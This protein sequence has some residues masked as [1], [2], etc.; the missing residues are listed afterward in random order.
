[1]DMKIKHISWFN[2][3]ALSIF[4]LWIGVSTVQAQSKK[5][6]PQLG[7]SP[8]AE[9][10]KAMTLEEKLQTVVGTFRAPK[11]PPGPPPGIPVRPPLPTGFDFD[12]LFAKGRIQGTAGE[13]FAIPR[14]GIP[15][16]V[17]ADGPAGLRIFPFRNK[18]SSHGYYAT[19]FPIATLMAST[20][21]TALVKRVGQAI[22]EELN[23]YGVDVLLSPGIN[24][25][26]NPL[27]GRNFEYFSEDPLLTGKL[28]AALVNG[29]QS[30][31][32]GACIKHFAANNQETFRNGV[33]A[34]I[35]ERALREIYLRGFEIAVKESKPWTMMSSYNRINDSFTSES[36]D[37]LTTILRKE[38]NYK[39]FVMT[40]WWAEY[41][42]VQQMKAGNDLLMPGTVEQMQDLSDAV[43]NGT[44]DI[45][46]IDDNV[47]HILETVVKS[48]AF[49]K[50]V[51]DDKPA[52]EN[53]AK[54][55]REAAAEGM[56]LLKNNQSILPF[57]PAVKAIAA[58][59]NTSYDLVVGGNGSGF[60]NRAYDVSLPDGL[61]HIGYQLNTDILGLYKKYMQSKKDSLSLKD[62][63]KSPRFV[64][65][66]VD[67]D[68]L[69]QAASTSDI[70]LITIGR[71]SGE[72]KD[73][74]LEDYYLSAGEKEMITKVSAAFRAKGKKVVAVL[75]IGGVIEIASWRDAFDA[76]LL[77]WQPGQEA[78]NAI[79]DVLS[80]KVNPSGKLATSFPMDYTDVPSAKNFP[81]SNNNPAEV[82]YEEGIYIGYRYYSSFNIPIA[83]PFGYGLSYSN[84]LYS[85]LTLTS[86]KSNG[87]IQV[88]V[89]VTNTG[90]IPGK[91]VVQLYISAPKAKLDKPALELKA[92]FKTKL[93]KPGES[94]TIDFTQDNRSL[95]SFDTE[96]SA[97][98]AD[99]GNYIVKVGTSST[100]IKQTASFVLGKNIIVEKV[101]KVLM[102]TVPLMEIKP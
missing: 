90:K 87:Q 6:L 45:K 12:A 76:I 24:I 95:A 89:T 11:L 31:G 46:I 42:A 71:N 63:L 74:K 73:R 32:V 35:S 96:A 93:L 72:G 41:S 5:T 100:D 99:A 3:L 98:I 20:W 27:T 58:F 44:L 64:E 69:E 91:E 77:A 92:F 15:G 36:R 61:Q 16:M 30:Q 94:Q 26:R 53:H 83:Y 25:H 43:K 57:A 54:L 47:S 40:D 13:G 51:H 49:K 39:G 34:I 66:M 38:W 80:G 52:L 56:V 68:V 59:G 28:A 88:S 81:S 33:N 82:K 8:M 86:K 102:P 10:I 50:Q 9:V 97:W 14:L 79:A 60:V 18:D 78:G 55:A 62:R 48:P 29:V 22:G 101:N 67:N 21:D 37:L 75:N 70:A 65:M 17:Y 23:S 4:Y 84:F 7:K 19:A 2:G 85:K 1:M